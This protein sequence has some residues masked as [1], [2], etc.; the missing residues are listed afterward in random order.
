M[1]RVKVL[2]PFHSKATGGYQVPDDVIE[3]TDEQLAEIR[4][5]NVNMVL[6]LD[7]SEAK[8]EEKPKTKAKKQKT[9][10]TK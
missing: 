4:E 8:A 6:V 10:T 7:E 3:V 5:V 2:V 9:K 1:N